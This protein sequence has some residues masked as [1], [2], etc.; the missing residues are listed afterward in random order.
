MAHLLVRDTDGA[1]LAR[2]DSAGSALRVL[3]RFRSEEVPLRGLS[4]VSASER[5]D[6]SI[7]TTPHPP[8]FGT[9]APKSSV[10]S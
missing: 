10:R 7:G 2:F 1:I 6:A 4:V 9:L 8:R 3:E 5:P